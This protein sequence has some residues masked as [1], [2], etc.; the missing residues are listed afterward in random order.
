M[1]IGVIGIAILLSGGRAVPIVGGEVF[2]DPQR[3]GYDRRRQEL[4][5]GLLVGCNDEDFAS[6]RIMSGG[7][8]RHGALIQINH[9]GNR[10]IY[11]ASTVKNRRNSAPLAAG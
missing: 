1:P 8:H 5:T 3:P 10:Q 2:F 4:A 9:V 7:A 11:F 6:T